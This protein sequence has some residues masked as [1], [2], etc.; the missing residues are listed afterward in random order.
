MG[1][2]MRVVAKSRWE[3]DD[4]IRRFGSNTRDGTIDLFAAW[5]RAEPHYVAFDIKITEVGADR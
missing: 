5:A 1:Y 4:V 2:E 3:T